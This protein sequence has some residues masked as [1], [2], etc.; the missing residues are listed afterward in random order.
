MLKF[1]PR[2]IALCART[3]VLARSLVFGVVTLGGILALQAVTKHEIKE[4]LA[5]Q[6]PGSRMEMYLETRA[7]LGQEFGG[8]QREEWFYKQR[9]YPLAEIP[10]GA[11]NEANAQADELDRLTVERRRNRLGAAA[12]LQ[13]TNDWTALGPQ[14]IR[15][16]QTFGVRNAVS[17]R[18]TAIALDPRYDG[19][20]NKTVYVG[21]AQGGVWKSLD[22][23][24]SWTPITDGLPTQAIGALAV[25]P[26]NPNVVWVGTGEAN[27]SGDS[28]YGAGLFKSVNGGTTWSQIVGPVST[29]APKE[30]VFLNCTFG[31]IAIH[32]TKPDTVFVATNV[33]FH[34]NASDIVGQAPLGNRGIWRTT[35]GGKTWLNVNPTQNRLDLLGSDVVIDPK[36]PS[37]VYLALVSEGIFRSDNDGSLLSWKELS[38]GLPA[39]F[40]KDGKRVYERIKFAIGPSLGGSA[41]STIYAAIAAPNDTLLGVYRSTDNGENWIRFAAP[42]SGQANYNLAFGADPTNGNVV[43][44]GTNA[45]PAYNGGVLYR[46]NNAAEGWRD[47]TLGETSGGL[48][49]DAHVVAI[50]KNNPNIMFNGN[51]GGI[52]RTDNA[53]A[54]VPIWINCNSG[55]NIT[56]FQS[57]AVDPYTSNNVIGGTQDNGTNGFYGSSV[58]EHLDDGDGGAVVID[59]SNP[60]VLYHTYFNVSFGGEAIIGPVIS[61]DGGL[62]WDERGCFPCDKV[63]QG[64]F[65][66]N[67]RVAFYAPMTANTAYGGESGNVI[68]FGTNR[69][70]RTSDRGVTWIGLGPSADGFGQS[71]TRLTGRGV[72]TTIAAFPSRGGIDPAGEI[73]WAGTDDGRVSVTANAHLL[74]K[75]VWF[76][77]TRGLPNRF[78]SDIAVDPRNPQRAIV[79]FS[80]FNRSTPTTPGHIFVTDNTG[81]TWTDISGDLPDT[82]LNSVILDPFKAN[83]FYVG[84]DLGVYFTTDRGKT[85]ARL[86]SSLPRVAVLQMRYH[87]ATGSLVAAT[88]GRGVWR[89]AVNPT[90]IAT[91]S[92]ASFS[93]GAVTPESIV[94]S[95]GQNLASASVS[96]STNPLPTTLGG[97]RVFVRDA[98][99]AERPAGIFFVSPAQVNFQVPL[100]TAAG[101][102]MVTIINGSGQASIGFM[103]VSLV[104]PSIFTSNAS[105]TGVPAGVVYRIRNG[106]ANYEPLVQRVGNEWQSVAVDV[107][108]TAEQVYLV[109]FGTGFRYR[110]GVNAAAVKLSAPQ[111]ALDAPVTYAGAQGSLVGLD[112]LNVRIPSSANGRGTV[113]LQLTVEGRAANPVTVR[114]R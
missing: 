60:Q 83:T 44:Y 70:Y 32:P 50:S 77:V 88:H 57:V 108:N 41:N 73:V 49:P 14:P 21:G 65:N 56:Q 96:A 59:Q 95:F 25:D 114:F 78:V 19:V 79:T 30:P 90:S 26:I 20:N 81:A 76:D 92:A 110:S 69:V 55:L 9:A 86:G 34:L 38:R 66:P 40:D 54:S 23:G 101:E 29:F 97:T 106:V 94:S 35:D 42:P 5:A 82:P 58:W 45:N 71:L 74:D 102:A 48:H 80:G 64:N 1:L 31:A 10:T 28:Y 6:S 52:W 67:D 75:A 4:I 109:L 2:A 84:T 98:F 47:I 33:G 15:L 112:Q 87:L 12:A 51:D 107:S 111:W 18:V 85:W 13:Q 103:R 105:G 100:A 113:T 61:F 46:S 39:R 63:I 72:V 7:S 89:M 53:L 36:N 17:G 22:N 3:S 16:G 91:V 43:Y 62:S 68:Y 24:A 11:H 93:G 104:A 37:R 8:A 99:G 27:R